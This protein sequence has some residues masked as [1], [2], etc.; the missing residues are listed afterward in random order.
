MRR[1]NTKR[2]EV[3]AFVTGLV[4]VITSTE[5]FSKNNVPK[6]LLRKF[7]NSGF[8]YFHIDTNILISL[9]VPNLKPSFLRTELDKFCT[10][11]LLITKQSD[12]YRVLDISHAPYDPLPQEKCCEPQI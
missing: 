8:P 11:L 12:R 5:R 4:K 9:V 1:K 6:F 7:K 2:E 3:K 10:I